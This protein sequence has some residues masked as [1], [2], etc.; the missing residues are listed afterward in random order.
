MPC[1]GKGAKGG[2]VMTKTH[3][4]GSALSYGKRY[5]F[6]LAFNVQTTERDDDGNAAG[7][8]AGPV[9]TE[10]QALDL[11]DAILELD[12]NTDAFCNHFKVE[13]VEDLPASKLE[14]A[15]AAI[16]KRASARR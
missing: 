6:G 4:V 3:A 14:T 12:P 5:A 8:E 2:D 9:I 11:R 10:K 15:K 16:A 1:D 13:R 7:R